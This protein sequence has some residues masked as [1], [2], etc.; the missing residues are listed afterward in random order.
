[1]VYNDLI[2]KPTIRNSVITNNRRNGFQIRSAGI[3][4]ENVTINFNGQSGMRYDPS[5]AALDQEDIV[6]WLSLREQP[7]LEANNIFRIP[8]HSLD[9]IEVMESN[10]NQRKFLVAA[11][12]TD[13]P[14][15]P[16]QECVYNLMIRA[17]G[18]QYG[19][20]S[21]MAI[22]MVNPPS[23]VSDEDAIFTE[24][25]T[26]KTWSARKDQIYVC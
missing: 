12:T 19:L 17:D 5:V 14:E 11:D 8:D 20:A 7:E 25:S 6:S 18:H 10:L 1:M 3:T 9:L 15:D 13:C 23:N 21:K 2:K 26:G 22:Q 4:V 16:L 24:V